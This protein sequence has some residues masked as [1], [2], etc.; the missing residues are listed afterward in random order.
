MPI[1]LTVVLA[2]ALLGAP[3]AAPAQPAGKI[4]R[5]GFVSVQPASTAGE[6]R[7][8]AF[9]QELRALGWV[10]G[11]NVV[12]E[13]RWG[14][15]Q[16]GRLP[17]LT[18]E[19]VRL[20]VDV[21]VAADA[22]STLAARKATRTIPIVMWC[23]VDPV[24]AGLVASLARPGGNV[25]GLTDVTSLSGKLLELLKETVPGLK[26]VAVLRNPA[27]PGAATHRREVEEAARA[28]ELEIQLLDV[29]GPGDWSGAF[30]TMAKGRSQALTMLLDA[31]FAR[32]RKPIADLAV[33]NR[34]PTV[35]A[36]REFVEA[37]GLMS[38]GTDR[39]GAYRRQAAY[40]DRILRG[41]KPADLPVE[42]PTKFELVVNLRTARALGLTI[43]PA[44]LARADEVIE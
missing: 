31:M 2:I 5:V 22:A 15:G 32:D 34:L 13:Y 44:V 30:A 28:L 29:R 9:G 16:E 14:E 36:R 18:A 43:P 6:S 42:Q 40:V 19:L 35:Y 10:E 41:A 7:F 33:K 26:R 11:Q 25:T 8:Q 12:V 27:G 17:A 21:I 3:L 24:K 39:G 23:P 1:T 37:G 20:Q 4:S 38:Y